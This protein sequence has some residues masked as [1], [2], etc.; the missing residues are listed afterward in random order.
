MSAWLNPIKD[1]YAVS[2]NELSVL[3]EDLGQE[4]SAPCGSPLTRPHPAHFSCPGA[5][6]SRHI[7][8]CQGKG[9]KPQGN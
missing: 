6:E 8:L 4:P 5:H 9:L 3:R 1:G 2:I 7:S